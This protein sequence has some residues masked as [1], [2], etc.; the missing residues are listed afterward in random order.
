MV[1]GKCHCGQVEF[2]VDGDIPEKLTRCTCSFC[3]KRGML[4]AYYQP[5]Q[6]HLVSPKS[7]DA[8]YRWNSKMV[9]HCFCPTCGCGTYSDTPDFQPNGAWDGKTRRIGVNARLFDHFIAANHPFF[10]IDGKNL[11]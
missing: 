5:H 11:W 8:I 6:F 9:D 1:T 4:W 3:S 7:N 10:E 2:K